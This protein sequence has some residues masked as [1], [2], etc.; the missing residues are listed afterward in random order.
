LKPKW[1][2]KLKS[3]A[4]LKRLRSKRQRKTSW[5]MRSFPI[6]LD[7]RIWKPNSRFLNSELNETKDS[8]FF[9]PI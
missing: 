1:K 5:S 4:E 7:Y 8:R 3:E 6:L 2:L 9:E